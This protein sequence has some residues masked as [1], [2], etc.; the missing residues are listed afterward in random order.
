MG[1]RHPRI[2]RSQIPCV[3]VRRV[4]PRGGQLQAQHEQ[5]VLL[6]WTASASPSAA[7][8]LT[9]TT[10]ALTALA[11]ATLALA[12][13]ALTIALAAAAPTLSTTALAAALTTLAACA[14]H[15][16]AQ[17]VQRAE[18]RAARAPGRCCAGRRAPGA[19]H[20]YHHDE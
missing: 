15:V 6:Q 19:G 18:P 10:H 13:A 7:L 11:F 3:H 16:T 1:Y 9:I 17:G 20:H 4:L 14:A 5:L 2:Q 12:A 8:T